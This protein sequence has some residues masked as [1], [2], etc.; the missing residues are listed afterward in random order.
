MPDAIYAIGNAT[1]YMH[2]T[3]SA[4][5]ALGRDVFP[6]LVPVPKLSSKSAGVFKVPG[7]RDPSDYASV[8]VCDEASAPAAQFWAAPPAAVRTLATVD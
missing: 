5:L 2:A 8:R 3:T 1:A 4:L 7:G 6:E